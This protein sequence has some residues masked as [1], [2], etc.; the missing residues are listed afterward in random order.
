MTL[1]GNKYNYIDDE[2]QNNEGYTI[3]AVV[4]KN[5]EDEGVTFKKA[6]VYSTILHPATVA[7]IWFLVVILG[8][9]G[10][11][12][13]VFNKPDM[14]KKKDIEFVRVDKAAVPRDIHTRNRAD[15]NSRSGG[16]RNKKM[17]V[18]MPSPKSSAHKSSQATE[19]EKMIKK[20]QKQVIKQQRKVIKQQRQVYKQVAKS[21]SKRAMSSHYNRP[22][23]SRPAP[24]SFAPSP[25]P[26][27]AP[28]KVALHQTSPFAI[29]VPSGLPM[30]KSLSTG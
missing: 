19:L 17:K 18:S 13:S 7:L 25:R 10:I 28:P 8:F 16:K 20:Q 12:F 14:N 29:P 21:Q 26:M 4:Q 5:S 9:L 24:P 30:G 22:A 11:T 1:L 2:E 27:S 15:E 3:P 6:L 23:T